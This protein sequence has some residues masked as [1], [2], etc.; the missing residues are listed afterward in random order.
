ML[1]TAAL[2]AIATLSCGDPEGPFRS[3]S[4]ERAQVLAAQEKKIVL[5]DFFTTWCGPCKKLDATTWKDAQVLEWMQKNCIALKVD[6][7]Q[8]RELAARFHV[9]AYPT[10][11]LLKADGTVIDRLVGYRDAKDFL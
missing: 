4:F 1:W 6:A 5:I 9:G 2:L 10:I 11:V 8:D 3:L 7:E